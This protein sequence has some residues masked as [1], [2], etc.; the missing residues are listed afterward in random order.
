MEIVMAA[1]TPP[2]LTIGPIL[3]HWPAEKKRAFY[4]RIAA[5]KSVDTVYIGETICGKR[6]PFFEKHYEDVTTEL[7]KAGKIV[8]FST[9]SEVMIPRD[10][11]LVKRACKT[12]HIEVEAND[13]SALLPLSGQPHRIGS[14]MNVYSEDTMRFLAEKGAHHFCLAPEIPAAAVETLAKTGQSL[15]AGVEV[16]VFGRMSLALSARCYHARA[17]GCVKANCQFICEKDA[18][19]MDIR[20]L[21]GRPFLSINGIQTLSFSYLNLIN[22]LDMLAEMGITHLR[23]SP[24]TCDMSKTIRAFADVLDKRITAREG[25]SR[26]EQLQ[27]QAPFSNGFFYKKPGHQWRED[28][29][30]SATA[31]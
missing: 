4:S 17:H 20:T 31:G 13:A 27:I 6:T 30:I 14:L 15:K 9:L 1:Q 3:F 8:V 23:I 18:D 10:R 21:T 29:K 26:L 12:K 28:E 2:K 7:Q 24:H 5:E 16:Q 25:Q 22:E 19:G 11:A